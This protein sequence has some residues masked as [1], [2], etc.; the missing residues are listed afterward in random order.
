MSSDHHIGRFVVKSILK[1]KWLVIGHLLTLILFMGV[2]FT[3]FN[4]TISLMAD[5]RITVLTGVFTIISIN[6]FIAILVKLYRHCTWVQLLPR[7]NAQLATDVL[8]ETLLKPYSFFQTHLSGDISKKRT[9]II[10]QV[11]TIY[12]SVADG[13]IYNIGLVVAAI[14]TLLALPWL[15]PVLVA[16][17][18]AIVSWKF[19]VVGKQVAKMSTETAANDAE[20][21]GISTDIMNNMLSVKLFAN[22][23]HEAKLFQALNLRNLVLKQQL[24][25]VYDHVFTFY[26]VTFAIMLA[27]GGWSM[28]SVFDGTL[29]IGRSVL[30]F[31]TTMSLGSRLWS[32]AL[33]MER[34]IIATGKL[35]QAL[36]LIFNDS[37][38]IK[39]ISNDTSHIVRGDIVFDNVQFGYDDNLLFDKLSVTIKH[40]ETVGL[41]GFSGAG[42]TTFVNLILKLFKVTSGAITIDN[43]NVNN[44]SERELYQNIA[45]ITQDCYLFN[46]SV[47]DNIAYGNTFASRDE[48]I[49]A[50]KLA[51]AHDFIEQ[52]ENGYD[53]SVGEKGSKLSGGQR[54]RIMIAR[55]ILKNAR[56]IIMDEVTSQLDS[57]N[58]AIIQANLMEVMRHKTAIV[59]AH[60]LSTL[61]T[62]DRLLVFETGRIIEDGSHDELMARNGVYAHLYRSQMGR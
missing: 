11:Q 48:V 9:D 26:S 7:L 52:L 12:M 34:Y 5:Q 17:W 58:E 36:R 27:I 60:R 3:A 1:F 50:A 6:A 24:E 40:G 19:T 43:V 2:A 22:E 59:I 30:F 20:L 37:S 13:F 21:N 33:E 45:M 54:Q 53:T 32:L 35:K 49:H 15:Y 47:L 62:M 28:Y 29:S 31:T 14:A 42:K 51:Q 18:V 25:R 39:H 61:R 4:Y 41:V 46:R 23:A 44:I 57:A 10:D 38:N 16:I 56:I 8:D 55:S